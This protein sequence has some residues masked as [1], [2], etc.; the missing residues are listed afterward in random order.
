MKN[1]V[2]DL[3][4]IY[5]GM[6]H[7]M[8][9]GMSSHA[10]PISLENFQKLI[11]EAEAFGSNKIALTSIHKANLRKT[12]NPYYPVLK[13]GQST[14]KFGVSYEKSMN[15]QR[16]REGKPEDFKAGGRPWGD[17]FTKAIV[18]HRGEPYLSILRDY[19]KPYIYVSK[20]TGAWDRISTEDAAAFMSASELAKH[21]SVGRVTPEWREYKLENI[22]AFTLN[23]QEYRIEPLGQNKRE[24]YSLLK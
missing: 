3:Q 18:I 13:I 1:D 4:L 11:H 8:A 21:N 12:N 19:V 22:V 9:F 23:G 5:E 16:K 10:K 14:G 24:I 2:V 15:Q 17:R 7:E 6:I 20:S